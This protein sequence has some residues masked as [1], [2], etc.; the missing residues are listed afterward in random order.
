MEAFLPENNSE[1]WCSHARDFY[2]DFETK[3]DGIVPEWHWNLTVADYKFHRIIIN[4]L[5]E[6]IHQLQRENIYTKDEITPMICNEGLDRPDP[7]TAA[8]LRAI[9]KIAQRTYLRKDKILAITDGLYED[10][11]IQPPEDQIPSLFQKYLFVPLS[12]LQKQLANFT[13]LQY[14]DLNCLIDKKGKCKAS[15]FSPVVAEAFRLICNLHIQPAF[16]NNQI[17]S[18]KERLLVPIWQLQKLLANFTKQQYKDLYRLINKEGKCRASDFSPEVAEAWRLICELQLQPAFPIPSLQERLYVPLGQL[19]TEL[20]NFT[21]KQYEDL[22]LLINRKERC[23]ASD[24][25]VEVGKAWRLLGELHIIISQRSFYAPIS[26]K[27]GLS[28]FF[29]TYQQ[30]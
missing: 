26:F 7:F 28:E 9:V 22:Y 24:F 8:Q 29:L 15:D 18:L 20:A 30:A 21:K 5:R 14:K 19:Q 12:Q 17:L 10:L 13:E 16:P 2:C 27:D 11:H 3:Y 1:S 4:A 23:K 6:S 25:S